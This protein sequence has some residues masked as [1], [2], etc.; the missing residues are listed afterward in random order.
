[1]QIKEQAASH[2]DWKTTKPYSLVLSGQIDKL[3]LEDVLTMVQKNASGMSSDE[4][5]SIVQAWIST[6]KHPVTGRPYTDM[7]YQPMLELLDY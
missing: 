3:S 6:A 4:F 7:V 1:D 5:T 2:P